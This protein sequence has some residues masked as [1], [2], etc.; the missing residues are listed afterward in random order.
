[1]KNSGRILIGILGAAAA[2]VVVGMIIAPKKGKDLRADIKDSAD[3]F[4]RKLDTLL[5]NGKDKYSELRSM[6]GVEG[7]EF[8]R[9]GKELVSEAEKAYKEFRNTAEA[10][11]NDFSHEA[12]SAI[13]K[14][15][16]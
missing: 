7:S 10:A 8:K 5:S 1:M 11:Y 6:I 3:E 2:G 9:D 12:N 16:S 13:Q 14:L 15:R 4:T